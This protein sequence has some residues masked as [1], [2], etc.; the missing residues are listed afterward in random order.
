MYRKLLRS[1]I[2]RATVTDSNLE[3]EGSITIDSDLMGNAGMMEYEL[4]QVVNLNNGARFETYV[5]SGKAGSGIIEINGA[6]ARLIHPGDKIIAMAYGLVL[7]EEL[8]EW[9][10]TIVLVDDD[11]QVKEILC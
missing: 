8:L 9:K 11:N 7:D 1:K 10:P 6:A 3:Y 5:I 4:V 2:H